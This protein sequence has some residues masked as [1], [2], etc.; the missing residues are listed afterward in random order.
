MSTVTAPRLALSLAACAMLFVAC[1]DEATAPLPASG[2]VTLTRDKG[3]DF[4]TGALI[5][6]GDFSNSDL[7]ARNNGDA[8]L[9]LLT[10]GDNPAD[11][12]P[13][14]WHRNAGMLPRT[15]ASL[16]EVPTDL[17]TLY[18]NVP[19][20]KTHFGFVLES[21]EGDHIRGWIESASPTSVTIQWDRLP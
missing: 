17:P 8:G 1:A 14:T 16:A 12:R 15:F 21:A 7:I 20:A 9:K 2:T 3:V 11:N 13:I 19:N 5:A 10:G 6:K 4:G 18:D